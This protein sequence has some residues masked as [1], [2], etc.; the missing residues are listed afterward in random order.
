VGKGI[1]RQDHPPLPIQ[2]RVRSASHQ[3]DITVTKKAKCMPDFVPIQVAALRHSRAAILS[4]AR[5]EHNEAGP[6]LVVV[7]VCPVN[8]AATAA[9]SSQ[10]VSAR[11]NEKPGLGVAVDNHVIDTDCGP[12]V[13]KGVDHRGSIES[14]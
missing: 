9:L 3:A 2:E 6:S 8:E 14:L 13:I 4:T 12:P 1:E 11:P 5:L 10:S 7:R